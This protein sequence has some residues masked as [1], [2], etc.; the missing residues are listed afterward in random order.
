[1][2]I[3]VLRKGIRTM[4]PYEFENPKR[5]IFSVGGIERVGEET[6]NLGKYVF[7]VSDI[8]LEKIGLTKQAL[9]PLKKVGCDV[10]TYIIPAREPTTDT[11]RAITHAVRKSKCDVIVGLGGGS[12]LD[13]AKLA[14][15]MATN[16]GDVLEYCAN[17]G[18]KALNNKT[19]PKLLIPTSSGTGS[20]ASNTL[21]IMEK[22]Y[23]TWIT[24]AKILAEVAL[25][26]P[27]L[28]V[29]MPQ[30][31]TANTGMDALSHVVEGLIST[32]ANP[33]SDALAMQAVYL[34]AGYLRRAYHNGDDLEARW[35]M[36]M[37]A[38]I[39]GWVIGFPW[40]GGPANLGHCIAEAMG[41]KYN[42]PHGLACAVSLL[43][44]LMF[45]LPVIPEKLAVIARSMGSEAQG[46]PVRKVAL[47]SVIAIKELMEDLEMPTSLK[48]LKVPKEDLPQFADYILK[49]RQYMYDLPHYNPR[50]LTKQNL[51]Q[52][53]ENMWEGTILGM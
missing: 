11:M 31:I 27:A 28:T 7:F 42:I 17:Y 36:S 13:S 37:A 51:N 49:E 8:N 44:T 46:L 2:D 21:V 40:I 5:I 6:K 35:F 22:N 24:D 3:D 48:D 14:S 53:L 30:R 23:K 52:L 15:V 32:R 4:I 45:N 19:L 25:V 1:M 43:G 26:D 20:E 10:K 50:K 9:K 12:V 34:V 16:P 33:L 18:E 47:K 39:G 38:M 29:S 41:P